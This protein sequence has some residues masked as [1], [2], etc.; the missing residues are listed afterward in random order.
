VLGRLVDEQL[1]FGQTPRHYS[2]TISVSPS[3]TA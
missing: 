1:A 2:S 3:L